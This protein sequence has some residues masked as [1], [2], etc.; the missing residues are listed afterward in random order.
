MR[1]NRYLAQRGY[2]TRREADALI[3]RGRVRVNG[4]RAIIGQHVSPDDVV[5]VDGKK[6]LLSYT[7]LA[8]HKPIGVVTN[9]PALGEKDILASI[10][11]DGVKNVRPVGRLDKESSGLILLTNDTRI[12]EPL[13]SPRTKHEK[14][15]R[16]TLNEVARPDFEKKMARGV[17]LSDYTTLPCKVTMQGARTFSIVLTE[18]KNRQIRRMVAALGYSVKRLVRTRIMHITLGEL[19]PNIARPLT[20]KE[21]ATLLTALNVTP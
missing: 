1:I 9:S 12:I 5:E 10:A 13:L 6:A 19:R 3:A 18:G 11:L 16:V 7:Y 8:Y 4:K 15:Y 14:E 17:Q 2:A 21:L 20:E